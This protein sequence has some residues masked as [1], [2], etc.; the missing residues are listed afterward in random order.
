[1][2]DR[3]PPTSDVDTYVFTAVDTFSK[4]LFTLPI[5]NKDALTVANAIFRLFTTFGVCNTL[6][7]DQGAEFIA[8]D[9]QELCA[10]LQVKQ[11]F[12][13]TFVHH[14]ED[15]YGHA[16]STLVEKVTPNVSNNR[17]SWKNFLPAIIF[18]YIG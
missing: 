15:A 6:V 10:S 4:Y 3:L 16:H 8:K 2:Y 13:P 17:N 11:E 5:K 1:M 18:E 14:C 7:S 9:T 12:T